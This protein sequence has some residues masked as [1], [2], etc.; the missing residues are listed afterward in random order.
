MLDEMT[1]AIPG[2]GRYVLRLETGD[3]T[4]RV[5]ILRDFAGEMLPTTIRTPSK[6]TPDEAYAVAVRR[7][8]AHL[9]PGEPEPRPRRRRDR[10]TVRLSL[11]LRGGR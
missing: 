6:A 1:L 4:Y 10:E 3:T 8:V 11:K 9:R 2:Q 7:L 5:D